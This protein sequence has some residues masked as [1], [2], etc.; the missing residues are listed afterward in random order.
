MAEQDRE[1]S[2]PA[3]LGVTQEQAH[4]LATML[5]RAISGEVVGHGP[6]TDEADYERISSFTRLMSESAAL[7]L[8]GKD[9]LEV[10][11][12][13]ARTWTGNED[14]ERRQAV[15]MREL[16]DRELAELAEVQESRMRGSMRNSAAG[17][18]TSSEQPASVEEIERFLKQIEPGDYN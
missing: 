5:R 10:V 12:Q 4:Y 11:E 6:G 13:A 3:E 7:A 15:Q 16:A 1:A 14:Q 17:K 8:E 18:S 2:A 9:F